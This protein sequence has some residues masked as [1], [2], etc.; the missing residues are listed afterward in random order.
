MAPRSAKIVPRWSWSKIAPRWAS[1]AIIARKLLCPNFVFVLP[2]LCCCFAPALPSVCL[3]FA[4]ALFLLLLCFCLRFAFM[5]PLLS[6]WGGSLSCTCIQIYICIYIDV[7]V[8]TH[9]YPRALLPSSP[10]LRGCLQT[11]QHGRPWASS[12]RLQCE[13]LKNKGKG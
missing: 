11:M 6:E 9:S 3:C 2:S 7:Q 10:A 8:A 12:D 1:W 5:L 4:F 13:F